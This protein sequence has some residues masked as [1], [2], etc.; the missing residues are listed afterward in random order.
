MNQSNELFQRCLRKYHPRAELECIERLM[1]KLKFD[2]GFT[3]IELL[4]IVTIFVLVSA[5]VFTALNP[6]KKLRETRNERRV[7]DITAILSAIQASM[8]DNNGAYPAGL[9]VG[10]SEAQL[11]TGNSGCAV[12]TGGCSVSAEACVDLAM[13][14]EKYLKTIPV[15]PT[16]GKATRTLYSVV[17]DTNG[18]VTVK[19]CG[20]EGTSNV[21]VSK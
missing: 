7:S 2:Q 18:V 17:V 12:S 3:F 20:S 5:C 8:M 6:A 10:M 9:T 15:D 14:L 4:V 13:P 16:A 11:G 21:S 19:A 1:K